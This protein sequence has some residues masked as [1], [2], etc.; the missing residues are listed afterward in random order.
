VSTATGFCFDDFG[1]LLLLFAVDRVLEPPLLIF[2]R[3]LTIAF[4]SHLDVRAAHGIGLL[5][6]IFKIVGYEGTYQPPVTKEPW[7]ARTDWVIPSL[8]ASE[9]GYE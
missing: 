6:I 5:R 3:D 8:P 4:L 1:L 7:D 9:L 2:D